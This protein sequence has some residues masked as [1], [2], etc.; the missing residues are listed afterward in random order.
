[1]TRGSIV[2]TLCI[3]LTLGWA[4]PAWASTLHVDQ[5]TFID[6]STTH[7]KNFDKF[8]RKKQ[9]GDDNDHQKNGNSQVVRISNVSDNHHRLGFVKFDLSALP[10]ETKISQALL[11]VWITKVHKEG[12]VNLHL[13]E[14]PWDEDT[15]TAHLVNIL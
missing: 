11:R 5:D 13:V 4:S 14:D 10:S 8:D 1:M 6:K 12:V 15:L 3:I 7:P 9:D 2:W